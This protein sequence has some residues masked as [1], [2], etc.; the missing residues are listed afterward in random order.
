MSLSS[1]AFGVTDD[2]PK[3]RL[4][5]AGERLEDHPTGIVF[6]I[7]LSS[8]VVL[9]QPGATHIPLWLVQQAP[10]PQAAGV[11]LCPRGIAAR[12]AETQKIEDT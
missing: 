11:D 5:L 1:R 10:C 2:A 8:P 7:R 9:G 4:G 12:R 6:G 3:R